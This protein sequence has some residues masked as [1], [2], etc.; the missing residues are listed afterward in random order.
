V[1]STSIEVSGPPRRLWLSSH[2]PSLNEHHRLTV[3]TGLVELLITTRTRKR[4]LT[5][6]PPQHWST[7]CHAAHAFV[8]CLCVSGHSASCPPPPRWYVQRSAQARQEAHGL[9]EIGTP[10]APSA[11]LA[12][13]ISF[14]APSSLWSVRF[15]V[16][17]RWPSAAL[18]DRAPLRR[19][20]GKG[21]GGV[22]CVGQ[23]Q[24]RFC[25]RRG[26]LCQG[27]SRPE[28][29]GHDACACWRRPNLDLSTLQLVK[30]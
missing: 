25:A 28:T 12:T 22:D 6:A 2:Q 4:G 24:W 30:Q 7:G 29:R 16:S 26:W 15:G 11:P 1:L 5:W 18:V 9:S 17:S 13:G 14:R 23:A 10:F 3:Q 27:C 20:R 21:R 19:C 8:V